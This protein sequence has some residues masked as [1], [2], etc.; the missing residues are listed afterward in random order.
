MKH[1]YDVDMILTLSEVRR[2]INSVNFDDIIWVKNGIPL[3]IS[4]KI[5][6]RHKFSGL[7]NIDFITSNFE[8]E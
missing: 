8:L 3:K 6:D 5:I 2:Q 1:I 7:N 4:K